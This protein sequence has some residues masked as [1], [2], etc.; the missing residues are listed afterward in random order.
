M[1]EKT[2]QDPISHSRHLLEAI[3]KASGEGKELRE[4]IEEGKWVIRDGECVLGRGST[5]WEAWMEAAYGPSR[6][7]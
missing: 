5:Q 6:P 1:M 3:K 7:D 2:P 4:S